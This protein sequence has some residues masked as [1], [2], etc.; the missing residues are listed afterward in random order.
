MLLGGH[1]GGT[2]VSQG[3][4]IAPA[5]SVLQSWRSPRAGFYVDLE[6]QRAALLHPQQRP[7]LAGRG[8]K[9]T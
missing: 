5:A 4:A 3:L 6:A 8:F 2:N 7:D 9:R 1:G